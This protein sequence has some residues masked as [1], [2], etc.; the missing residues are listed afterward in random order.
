M[1]TKANYDEMY[2]KYIRLSQGKAPFQIDKGFLTPT[3][4]EMMEEDLAYEAFKASSDIVNSNSNPA[5]VAFYTHPP[6]R[7]Q[8]GYDED[9]DAML[10]EAK[11]K[12]NSWNGIDV[13]WLWNESDGDTLSFAVKDINAGKGPI[14]IK[15]QKYKDFQEYFATN[16][17][18]SGTNP[19]S[20]TASFSARFVGINCAELPHYSAKPIKKSLVKNN[21]VKRTFGEVKRNPKYKF[22]KYPV[23]NGKVVERKDNDQMLFY[24]STDGVFYEVMTNV[25]NKLEVGA[26]SKTVG[27][28]Y[29]KYIIPNNKD[30][31]D[32]EKKNKD[33]VTFL[34]VTKDDTEKNTVLDAY[35]AQKANRNLLAKS[36]NKVRLVLDCGT[37]TIANKINSGSTAISSP[38]YSDKFLELMHDEFKRN[39]TDLRLSGLS[40]SL[41]G[42]DVYGRYLSEIYMKDQGSGKWINANKYVLA[43]SEHTEAI[44]DY[45]GQPELNGKK[46]SDAFQIWTY[47]FDNVKWLDAFEELGEKSYERRIQI[48]ENLSGLKFCEMR[49]YSVLI[50]DTLL[51]IPPTNI[52]AVSQTTYERI[53]LLRS[54][55]TLTK[56]GNQNESLIEMSLFFA[57]DGGV[58]GIPYEHEFPNGEK[59]T[60]YMNGLRSLIAQFKLTPFLPIENE[61]INDV[62]GIEAVSLLALDTETV[63]EFPQL[64]KVTLTFRD[65]NYRLFM[66]DLPL[67]IE[68]DISKPSLAEMNP[69][70]AKSFQW[71]VFRYYYQRLMLAGETLHKLEYNSPDYNEYM[72]RMC[73]SLQPITFCSSDISIFIPDIDW[74]DS[75]LQIKKDQDDEG[76]LFTPPELT[77]NARNVAKRLASMKEG[78]INAARN[79]EDL[80]S[81]KEYNNIKK[82]EYTESVNHY[83]SNLLG[84]KSHIFGGYNANANNGPATAKE[85]V[86]EQFYRPIY[87][88]LKKD[89]EQTG[90]VSEVKDQEAVSKNDTGTSVAWLYKIKI[91][92]IEEELNDEENSALREYLANQ[93]DIEDKED[94][95]KDGYIDMALSFDFSEGKSS[96]TGDTGNQLKTYGFSDGKV[97]K[98]FN[99]LEKIGNGEITTT[100]QDAIGKEEFDWK[101]PSKMK[102][103]PYIENVKVT[104]ISISMA[105]SFT[106][107]SLKS[108]DGLSAQYIGGQDLKIDMKLLTCDK[109]VV[110]ALNTLPGIAFEYVNKYRRIISC[111]PIRIKNEV[112]QMMGL[113]EVL[114]DMI[115]I[116]TIDGFPGAY[117]ITLK[118]SSVDRT[119]R[120]RENLRKMA[121]TSNGGFVGKSAGGYIAN[122]SY[123]EI[124]KVLSGVEVYPDLELPSL[125]DLKAR[126]YAYIKYTLSNEQRVY[127]DPDFYLVYTYSYTAAKLKVLIDKYFKTLKDDKGSLINMEINDTE[128][129][130]KMMAKLDN[131]VGL[132]L[133]GQC[134][135]SDKIDAEIQK[136]AL[137]LSA[138]EERANMKKD[139]SDKKKDTEKAL[140]YLLLCDTTDGW[141]IKPTWSAPLCDSNTNDLIRDMPRAGTESHIP[142]NPVAADLKI[143]RREAIKAIDSIL[144]KP[145]SIKPN[146][147]LFVGKKKKEQEDAIW[148]GI[149]QAIARVFGYGAVEGDIEHGTITGIGKGKEL[150]KLLNPMFENV[151]NTTWGNDY[152]NP[153][154]LSY[155]R[156]FMY[157]AACVAS[158]EKDYANNLGPDAIVSTGW[159]PRLYYN[160]SE[161]GMFRAS[162]GARIV[163]CRTE[164][165]SNAAPRR[166][167]NAP[168]K[169]SDNQLESWAIDDAIKQGTVFGP[170]G[171]RKYSS[172]ELI[173]MTT[174]EL[175]IKY[176][177]DKEYPLFKT[178][179]NAGFLD[180]YY[181]NASNKV[182]EEY[183]TGLLT[184]PEYSAEAY[185]RV[186]LVWMRKLILDGLFFSDLDSMA[187]DVLDVFGGKLPDKKD[188]EK[189]LKEANKDGSLGSTAISMAGDM[190][191]ALQN[192]F[193]KQ[194]HVIDADDVEGQYSDLYLMMV[195]LSDTL[196]KSFCMRLIYPVLM[197]AT[198]S[199]PVLFNAMMNRDYTGLESLMNASIGSGK[200]DRFTADIRTF[201]S[202]M[203]GLRMIDATDG[204]TAWS[205]ESQKMVNAMMQE[206]Y[207]ELSKDPRA[208]VM[209]SYYDMLMNDKRGR[210]VR[211]FPTYYMILV[212]EGRKIGHWKLHDNFYNMSSIAEI[213]IVKSRKN[214]ADTCS[215][216]MTNMYNSYADEYDNATKY[217]YADLY[218][219]KDVFYN[220]FSPAAYYQKADDIRSK[221]EVKDTVVL[222][223]GT[224]MHIKMGYGSDASRLPAAFNGRIAEL[225]VGETVE[226]IAQ[227]DGIELV[228]PLNALGNIEANQIATAQTWLPKVF[229]NMRGSLFEGG[230]Y[231]PKN[232]LANVLSAE[233]G[234]KEKIFSEVSNNR[235]FNTNP[236]GI[237]HFGDQ[238]YTQIFE[239]G[240]VVQNLYEVTDDNILPNMNVLK[241]KSIPERSTPIINVSLFDK[242]FW[243][244]MHISAR[245]GDDYVAAIRDFGF[246]STIFLGRPNYYYAYAYKE[247]SG[248]IYEKRK[249]FQQY[250]FIDSYGDIVYNAMKASERDIKTNATGLWQASSKIH[251]RKSKT[252][253]PVY[254]DANIYPEYQKAMTYDTGLLADGNGGIDIPL[255][256]SIGEGR[257]MAG[258]HKQENKAYDDKVN[259]RLAE[260]MTINA[261]KDTVKDMYQGDVCIIGNP[262]IKPFDRISINDTYEDMV[263]DFEVESVVHTLNAQT[264]FTTSIHPDLIVRQKQN[265]QELAAKQVNNMCYVSTYAILSAGYGA[266]MMM[267]RVDSKLLRAVLKSSPSLAISSASSAMATKLLTS[268]KAMDK[269]S[270]VNPDIATALNK[271]GIESAGTAIGKYAKNLS[272]LMDELNGIIKTNPPT[273]QEILNFM[274]RFTK[275]D[276]KQ[277][278]S[279]MDNIAKYAAESNKM[280]AGD[281]EKLNKSYSE[282]QANYKS[283]FGANENAMNFNSLFESIE[284][285]E[286]DVYK[287]MDKKLID[288]IKNNG[289]Y[290]KDRKQ[291]KKLYD[292]LN[293]EHVLKVLAHDEVKDAFDT[294]TKSLIKFGISEG[295]EEG[296]EYVGLK[297]L[298]KNILKKLDDVVLKLGTKAGFG[299]P[300][301][302]A[303]LVLDFTVSTLIGIN[304]K[305]LF[306]AWF[307]NLQTLTIF[308]MKQYG[309]NYTAGLSGAKTCVY[310]AP[311][312]DGYNSIQGMVIQASEITAGWGGLLG[313]TLGDLAQSLLFNGD[314][315]RKSAEQYKASLGITESSTKSD[316]EIVE[317]VHNMVSK[318]F[319][320]HSDSVYAVKT[321]A[322]YQSFDTTNKDG[323]G[324]AAY[325]K[326]AIRN[327]NPDQIPASKK[328][329]ELVA[330]NAYPDL[331]SYTKDGRLV[332]AHDYNDATGNN[333]KKGSEPRPIMINQNNKQMQLNMLPRENKGVQS[334]DLPMLQK[335]AN[336]VL[337][338][339]LDENY[340]L[341]DKNAQ[342]NKFEVHSATVINQNS[343]SSTGYRFVIKAKHKDALDKT[344]KKVDKNLNHGTFKVFAYAPV[345]KYEGY[346]RITVYPEKK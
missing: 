112:T 3:M 240:E 80:L 262:S 253:G 246:R 332:L 136:L 296:A 188:V 92:M 323:S 263:G 27:D 210:L 36:G 331:Q 193:S 221:A 168:E 64:L 194:D 207:I 20:D 202:A 149:T 158:A 6:F 140:K 2:N 235:F 141:K 59:C 13:Q 219:I 57:K 308:P 303:S 47:E 293:T 122:R 67:G 289:G 307:D 8:L 30:M 316:D 39:T 26:P 82:V 78:I 252:V 83:P 167:K 114:L 335:D 305:A 110:S 46:L 22:V 330:I 156:G 294:G 287:K 254:L 55:G 209:H 21:M 292:S 261:L 41:Y 75:A 285:L 24:A 317:S 66:P 318:Q 176:V 17:K 81:S 147:T 88:S 191:K 297:F 7:D 51:M 146:E 237:L 63:P 128:L 236:F 70:F 90:M 245:A 100:D 134:G 258:K 279:H 241:Q 169:A 119:I 38:F 71:E 299:L 309:R 145:I 256:T 102:F 269:L 42:T 101:D 291:L 230:G 226:I 25:N 16:P 338:S 266:L 12:E 268:T 174:P 73:T 113:N 157:S 301:M 111:S 109:L 327:L 310:G 94:I 107:T 118:M 197:A 61:Y 259:I 329:S 10:V 306:A 222:K 190:K 300:G 164:S 260:V 171:I 165:G 211:A 322:R 313:F 48:H 227:G 121:F 45:T 213:Q 302:I 98:I 333:R 175:N 272:L 288:S 14:V 243:D 298:S 53:P 189:K 170:F 182:V 130:T 251:G 52:R 123:F 72:Y 225:N 192:I 96:I 186:I 312:Q 35:K 284:K 161:T 282:F 89:L 95:L 132:T 56:G 172:D 76:V 275:L 144:S 324:M 1:A 166:P 217:Q 232:L 103:V 345:T 31:M 84:G 153:G 304:S 179:P 126:G 247:Q 295:A 40:Y 34:T 177:D 23:V 160:V 116:N 133:V 11:I 276:P 97:N 60:Y 85:N 28:D 311:P 18:F 68:Q 273:T 224:R 206:A 117:E 239:Q 125:A 155:L 334:W 135:T 91:P 33:H 124:D 93:L 9:L 341:P 4:G 203:Y 183:M 274:D 151:I 138:Q 37:F 220:I 127:P 184:T 163:M 108:V 196:P 290:V 270:K 148:F 229:T 154:M 283:L 223:P 195:S 281:L 143:T 336:F 233:Y 208:Y 216:I 69:I 319:I 204:Q 129:N 205:D 115:D 79:A 201:F 326:Y 325:N 99:V 87:D 200:G 152:N 50:G 242:T 62:L 340:K 321:R 32:T 255:F 346:Y 162:D 278:D 15:G 320:N 250:H 286:P 328:V 215:V 54:K 265:Q 49:E 257:V 105:N 187:K 249:P 199:S 178:K 65:F 173:E 343:W 58:N 337:K 264:G 238:K 185:I 228:N 280:D 139:K 106:E 218:G 342:D 74:L 339:I 277:L 181:N 344:L 180:P 5:K 120:Q 77:D 212:D 137:D 43:N 315:F 231:S 19:N 267:S 248:N 44:P 86:I 29:N 142:N 314:Q 198:D 150:V 271:A 159:G 244:L 104:N 214:P 234:G 131:A